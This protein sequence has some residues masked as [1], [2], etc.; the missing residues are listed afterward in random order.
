M[1]RF[2]ALLA[3]AGAVAG[4][5]TVWADD[6]EI[7]KLESEGFVKLFDGKTLSGWK[8]ADNP[9]SWEALPDGTIRGKGPRSHLFSPKEYTDLEFRAEIKLKKGSN[10]GMYFRTAFG[11]GWPKGYEAQVNNS[12]RD[13]VRTGSLYYLVP[14]KEQLVPDDTWWTQHII[15]KGNHII[16]KVNGKTVVDYVDAKNTY[17]KGHLAFQQHDPMSEVFFRNVMVKDLSKSP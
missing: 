17:T 1:K 14:V 11:S 4:G 8:T 3:V 13:P 5:N 2:A 7:K 10:S 15:C 16:I 9:E 6:E 12:G